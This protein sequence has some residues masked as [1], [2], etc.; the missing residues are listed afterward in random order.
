MKDRLDSFVNADTS[1]DAGVRWTLDDIAASYTRLQNQH[2]VESK[3]FETTRNEAAAKHGWKID[4]ANPGSYPDKHET[5]DLGIEPF[6]LQYTLR[7]ALGQRLLRNLCEHCR[8][9]VSLDAARL[10]QEG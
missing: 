4:A 9:S 2:D 7:A 6:L 3:S 8:K 5:V 1:A 10:D